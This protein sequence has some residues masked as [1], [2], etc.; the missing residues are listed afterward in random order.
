[1]NYVSVD[2][3][4]F[5]WSYIL[6][7]YGQ[8]YQNFNERELKHSLLIA[9]LTESKDPRIVGAQLAYALLTK[10]PFPIY[11]TGMA[12]SITEEFLKINSNPAEIQ[13]MRSNIIFEYV[14]TGRTNEET[15]INWF[16][17]LNGPTESI[18]KHIIETDLN[19]IK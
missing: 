7:V 15:L 2:R 9:K 14:S 6:H 16:K 8:E 12:I 17:Q 10:K 11:N 5:W 3:I 1:M 18:I 4:G 19:L 13:K